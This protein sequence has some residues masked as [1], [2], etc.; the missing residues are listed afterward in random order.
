MYCVLLY[1]KFGRIADA[2]AGA[3]DGASAGMPCMGRD[4]DFLR[5]E[6]SVLLVDM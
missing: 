2:G 1:A 5:P 6:L 3:R 4:R